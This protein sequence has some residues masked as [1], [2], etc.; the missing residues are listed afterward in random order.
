MEIRR[1]YIKIM[2]VKERKSIPQIIKAFWNE[3]SEPDIPEDVELPEELRKPLTAEFDFIKE[4]P[5]TRSGNKIVIDAEKAKE[6]AQNKQRNN[7]DDGIQID[8]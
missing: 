2:R 3:L 8:M 4:S 5:R 6:N 7:G 1:G